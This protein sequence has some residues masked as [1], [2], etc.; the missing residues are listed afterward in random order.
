[1][2]HLFPLRSDS[3]N[4]FKFQALRPQNV[5]HFKVFSAK[6]LKLAFSRLALLSLSGPYLLHL[7]MDFKI[8]LHSCFP[9][10]VKVPFEA[11]FVQVGWKSRSHLKDKNYPNLTRFTENRTKRS[12]TASNPLGTQRRTNSETD[13]GSTSRWMNVWVSWWR[14]TYL[15]VIVPKSHNHPAN[16]DF[17]IKQYTPLLRLWPFALRYTKKE[18]TFLL[19]ESRKVWANKLRILGQVI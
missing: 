5:W 11:A 8:I 16:V 4:K 19:A 2:H 18:T 3:A 15:V 10:R 7:C 12:N 17:D 13:V 14:V 1:M 6:V 9:W